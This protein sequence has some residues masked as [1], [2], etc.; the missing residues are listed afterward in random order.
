MAMF[1][2]WS[3]LEQSAAAIKSA[4]E[5]G[6]VI[7]SADYHDCELSLDKM[8]R[9]L[10]RRREEHRLD[11]AERHLARALESTPDDHESIANLAA[12]AHRLRKRMEGGR[13]ESE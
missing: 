2:T 4:L 13:D 9:E 5:G 11:Y 7:A 3:E 6:L 10:D 1:L 8:N 12:F